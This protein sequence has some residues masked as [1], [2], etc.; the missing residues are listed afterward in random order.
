MEPKET[1]PPQ[2]SGQHMRLSQI[3]FKAPYPTWVIAF[4]GVQDLVFE[5]RIFAFDE[6]LLFTGLRRS[7]VHP[8]AALLSGLGGK[9]FEANIVSGLRFIL[10]QI[11]SF[12]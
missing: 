10:R 12:G 2:M 11:F 7:I 9:A 4:N 1:G 8:I 3:S 6:L 5:D